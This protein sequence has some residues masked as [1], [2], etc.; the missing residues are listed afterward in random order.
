M[1]T[2]TLRIDLRAEIAAAWD[3]CWKRNLESRL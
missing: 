2:P 1:K 3:R